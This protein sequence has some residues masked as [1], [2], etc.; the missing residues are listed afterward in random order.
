[1]RLSVHCKHMAHED[2]VHEEPI[3]GTQTKICFQAFLGLFP[4]CWLRDLLLTQHSQGPGFTAMHMTGSSLWDAR[5][6]LYL[7]FAHTLKCLTRL[8]SHLATILVGPF[9]FSVYVA[10][11]DRLLSLMLPLCLRCN[12]P[13]HTLRI[14]LECMW[15]HSALPDMTPPPSQ[16]YI[17]LSK[18]RHRDLQQVEACV[19]SS[20]LFIKSFVVIVELFMV[21]MSR[22]CG[23]MLASD[24]HRLAQNS[25]GRGVG[26]S[27]K[28]GRESSHD[29]W[30][31]HYTR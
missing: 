13:T 17:R 2:K 7:S 27:G 23:H 4:P 21:L 14:T 8:S 31:Y 9:I 5:C 30:N 15:G 3:P 18:Q 16:H 22:T 10:M 19:T 24:I 26:I 29:W 12:T 1:M 25:G 28:G 11:Q 20:P 6:T